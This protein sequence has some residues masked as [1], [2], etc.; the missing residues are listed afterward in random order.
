MRRD[1]MAVAL[2]TFPFPATAANGPSLKVLPRRGLEISFR[3]DEG[4][5]VRMAFL[6][7]VAFKCAYLPAL[8]ATMIKTSY[9]KLVDLG[10][11]LWRSECQHL[12]DKFLKDRPKPTIRHLQVCFDDGPCYDVLCANYEVTVG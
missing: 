7:V 6:D 4:E 9:G 8:T 11:T 5:A 10:E 2:W 12:S 1:K 3:F